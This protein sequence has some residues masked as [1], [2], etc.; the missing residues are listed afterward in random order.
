MFAMFLFQ[1]FSKTFFVILIAG[2][3][4]EPTEAITEAHVPKPGQRV[5]K[6]GQWVPKPGERVPKPGQWVPKPGQWVPKPAQRVPL[7][8]A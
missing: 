8:S 7:T 3:S 6:P 1:S 2:R 5:P 4:S